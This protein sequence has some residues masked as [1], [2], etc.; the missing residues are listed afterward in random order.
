MNEISLISSKRL[1]W[2][3]R[4]TEALCD[5]GV[6]DVG[7]EITPNVTLKLAEA[8]GFAYSTVKDYLHLLQRAGFLEVKCCQGHMKTYTLNYP[9]DYIIAKLKGKRPL[10]P[11]QISEVKNRIVISEPESVENLTSQ[12]GYDPEYKTYGDQIRHV[13]KQVFTGIPVGFAQQISKCRATA[14]FYLKKLTS[15]GLLPSD[16]FKVVSRGLRGHEKVYIIHLSHDSTER[17]DQLKRIGYV[18]GRRPPTKPLIQPETREWMDFCMSI[19][20]GEIKRIEMDW[21]TTKQKLTKRLV[22]RGLLPD[23][24]NVWTSGRTLSIQRK[25]E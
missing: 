19:K 2:V 10:E 20:K 4:V 23:E 13:W 17:Q 8:S 11:E 9:P 24:F 7:S 15:Q 3:C 25:D 21:P 1:K 16:E 5:V 6:V 12:I 18:H 22:K 14:E